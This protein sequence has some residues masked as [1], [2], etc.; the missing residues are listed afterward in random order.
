MEKFTNQT[1]NLNEKAV[2][3]GSSVPSDGAVL[4]WF[5]SEDINPGNSISV[6]DVSNLIDENNVQKIDISEPILV[7]ADELG[8]L[9]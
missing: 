5:N 8:F 7:Y 3:I 4:G 9:K 2:K 6:V 1:E